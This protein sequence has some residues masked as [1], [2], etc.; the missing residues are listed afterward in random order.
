MQSSWHCV[1]TSATDSIISSHLPLH[2]S[3]SDID[4][5]MVETLEKEQML[6][7]IQKGN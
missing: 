2:P 4:S 3:F 7:A 5:V 1:Y 6:K